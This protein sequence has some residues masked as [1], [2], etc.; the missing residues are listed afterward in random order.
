MR[1]G[2]FKQIVDRVLTDANQ[3]QIEADTEYGGQAYVVKNFAQFYQALS[4]LIEQS[5]ND[6]PHDELDAVLQKY[7]GEESTVQL[8]TNDYNILNNYISSVNKNLPVAMSVIDSLAPKQEEFTLNI[9]LPED[10]KSVEDLQEFNERLNKIFKKF[11]I[12]G[13][14]NFAGFDKGSDWYT[15]IITTEAL[16]KYVMAAVGLAIA[17]LTLRKTYYES[18]T[19]KLAYETAKKKDDNLTEAKYLSEIIATKTDED[20]AELVKNLGAPD[21]QTKSEMIGITVGTVKDLIKELGHGTEFHMSLNPPDYLAKNDNG[22]TIDYK[23]I[24]K[25][26][27]KQVSKTI[28]KLGDGKVKNDDQNGEASK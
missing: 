25:I 13:D 4:L 19:A 6:S 9:Q 14:F 12:T 8:T 3:L 17:L 27:T 28:E 11:N 10:I 1:I 18:E 15:V 16:Y 22:F 26:S 2:E 5:W 23:S 24:P 21:N 20:A 7:T